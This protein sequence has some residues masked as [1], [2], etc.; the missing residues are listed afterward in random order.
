MCIRDRYRRLEYIKKDLPDDVKVRV[1]FDNTQFIRNSIKEVKDTIYIAFALVVIIIYF[2]L[3]SWRATLI[4]IL[5]IPVSLIGAFFI[6][7][8]AG[9]AINV[10]TLLAIVLAIG[11]VVDDAIVVMENIYVKVEN[12]VPP[13]QAG[14]EGSNEIYFAIIAT[15]IT[16]IAVFFPIVF[17]QGITGRLFRE[18]AIVMAGAVGISAFLALSLTPMVSTKM[19]R[20]ETRHS[21]FYRK[22]EK[23]FDGLNN[24]YKGALSTFLDNR[25][26]TFLILVAAMGLIF[27]LWKSI[28]AEMAPL[29]DR[30]Q[31]SINTISQEGSTYE[32]CLLY[33]SPS[34][35]DRTRYRMP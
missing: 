22:T 29:E 35:R 4:P 17:L 8:L 15:T 10:L 33:T 25:R 12:G 19:L 1:A 34:P 5:V 26:V 20:H 27:F 32:F 23:F 3:R 6:M 9:Y 2:F 14:L 7:Y 28:P 11:I 24:W 16:L 21:W 18:F 13:V 30:S 31:I